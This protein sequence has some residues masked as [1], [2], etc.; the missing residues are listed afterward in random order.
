VE[1]LPPLVRRAP[2]AEL[3]LVLGCFA[4]LTVL[5][6]WPTAALL[7]Q[8][9]D[10][11]GDVVLQLTTM[12]WDAHA[13]ATDPLHLFDA[14][15]FYPYY[16]SLAYSDHLLGQTL[17]TWPI[18]A[19]SGNPA[20]ALNSYKLWSFVAT[21]VGTYLLVRDT[22]GS[23]AAGLVA[24]VAFAF[25]GLRFMQLTHLHIL[26][27]EW[28]PLTIWALRRGLARNSGR[29]LALAAVFFAAMALCSVYHSYF[30]ALLAGGYLL[31]W[32]GVWWFTQRQRGAPIRLWGSRPAKLALTG[33]VLGPLLLPIYIPYLQVN[34]E[35]GLARSIYEVQ[36]WSAVWQYYLRVL[37]SNWF[38][39][40]LRP[41]M[42][43]IAGE[44]ELFPG[45]L[46]LVLAALGIA[47]GGRLG[48]TVAGA[49]PAAPPVPAPF[50]QPTRAAERWYWVAAGIGALML[51]FGLSY[52]FPNGGE[53]PLPYALLYDWVPGFQALRVPVR[54]AMLVHLAL[55]VLA[56]YGIADFGLRIADWGARRQASTSTFTSGDV[57]RPSSSFRIPHSAL[58]I[59]VVALV[60]LGILAEDAQELDLS[61][62]RDVRPAQI[63]PYSW[64]AA[65][66]AG[67]VIEFPFRGDSGDIWD[68]YWGTYHWQP[69]VNGWSGF[70]PPGTV[71]LSR[72]LAAFPDGPTVALLQ[73][74]EVGQV[75]VHLWQYPKDQQAGLRTRLDK[76]AGLTLAH[77]AGED[78]VYTL[79]ADPWLRRLGAGGGQVWFGGGV[80]QQHP[81]MEVLAYFA[82]YR[83]G[84][85][86][87]VHGDVPLGYR[88]QPPLPWGT[89]ADVIVQPP[90][91]AHPAGYEAAGANAYAA[92]YARNAGLLQRYDLLAGIP[93][94]D[95][96]TFTQTQ[97]AVRYTFGAY[98]TTT[99]TLPLCTGGD[100]PWENLTIPPGVST[101]I[102]TRFF[103]GGLAPGQLKPV[104][105]DGARLLAAE[106]WATM[107][108][109]DTP[110]IQPNTLLLD[111]A[112]GASSLS[113]G[114]IVSHV[115][116]VPRAPQDG[117]Y[118]LTL[119]VYQKPWGTHPDGHYG[120]FSL[121]VPV[122]A[123]GRIYDLTLHPETKTTTALLNGQPAEVFAWQG[124]PTEG[125]FAASLVLTLGDR[126]IAHVPLYDFTLRDGRLTAV[127]PHPG[128]TVVA[129]LAGP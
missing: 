107:P 90:G 59:G 48:R 22:T 32:A 74:L 78:Y 98:V 83:L 112:P 50:W 15:F 99:V 91:E 68:A 12:T 76:T 129:P 114:E 81:E 87:R 106:L 105:S 65:H 70:V 17:L 35:L 5:M 104:P 62:H 34:N 13:L 57:V 42:T 92:V 97:G 86:D 110:G 30:L 46:L 20:L 60:M 8:G 80:G 64:V 79:A 51:T 4:G 61:N 25:T 53:I 103:C 2:W 7:D 95:S 3:L 101:Y 44:R 109:P 115:R 16:H 89:P 14:P 127:D 118:T 45:L 63:E 54:F 119:D 66:P 116:L 82:R 77:Q 11:F 67:P 125:D 84:W 1:S 100:M 111:T 117:Q 18:F 29:W 123:D 121:P 88:A 52:R 124:P 10:A 102:R 31:W 85:G 55:A 26:A 38:W 40:H 27:T 39:G 23:R 58:R 122:G 126:L 96:I 37:P 56:G 9:I 21:G 71:Y 6:T 36:N 128:Q 113:T 69:L 49:A 24:G 72:A 41:A 75:V 43:S 94:S 93:P 120:T 19:L 33:V 47:L 108:E 28:F 73:G